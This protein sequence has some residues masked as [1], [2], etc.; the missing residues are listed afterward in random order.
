MHAGSSPSP[1]HRIIMVAHSHKLGGI[2]RNVH[3]LARVLSEA[4]HHVAYAGPRD[5]WLGEAM[6]QAG[7]D[8]L[9]LAMN[10]MYDP[11]SAWKLRRFAKRWGADLL[12]GHAQRGTRYARWAAAGRVAVIASAHST[13]AW[14]W[15]GP[16]HPI[17]AVSQA[18]RSVLLDKGFTPEQVRCVH[19]GVPDQGRAPAPPPGPIRPERPLV[20]GILGRLEQVKGHD[21]ALEALALLRDRLPARLVF[22]GADTTEW[23]AQMKART[24]TLGLSDRVEFWGQR[25]DIAAV[26]AQMDLMLAPSYREALSLSLLETCAAGRPAIGSNLGGIPEVIIPG[27]NGLLVPPSDPEALA[28]A[29]MQLAQ[30]DALRA[31]MGDA[32]RAVFL[33]T[34]TEAAMRAGTEAGY[35]QALSQAQGGAR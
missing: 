30:D 4:G 20:M 31:R 17:L 8:S 11:I 29:I 5:G 28:E 26:F 12:H 6:A 32:A 23:A 16:N 14:K 10:G 27:Q 21:T 34:F 2:E 7:Y 25:S 33:Q 13:T 15:F 19:L 35:A 24:E 9:D 18:V 3:A 22:V 1:R